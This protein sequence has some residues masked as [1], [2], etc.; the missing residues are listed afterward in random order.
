MIG[1]Q[2]M[3]QPAF[4]VLIAFFALKQGMT[5]FQVLGIGIIIF[6]IYLLNRG[7]R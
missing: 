5:G 1:I 6:N 4:A 7:K 3:I 2:N